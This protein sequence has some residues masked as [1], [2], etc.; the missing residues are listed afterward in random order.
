MSVRKKSTP[1]S[2]DASGSN[3]YSNWGRAGLPRRQPLAAGGGISRFEV[4]LPCQQNEKKKG[5][6][7]SDLQL[8]GARVAELR[9]TKCLCGLL[10]RRRESLSFGVNIR[11]VDVCTMELSLFASD[12][13]LPPY[14]HPV[15][16]LGGRR[17]HL[18][19]DVESGPPHEPEAGLQE[20]PQR[21][22][23]RRSKSSRTRSVVH[24]CIPRGQRL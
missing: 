3:F 1:I 12:A 14:R 22:Q 18:P 23:T 9:A 2:V 20:D 21:L 16:H 11:L 4:P 6:L 15:A 8:D 19:G 17:G 5:S 10:E 7:F 24:W 13:D